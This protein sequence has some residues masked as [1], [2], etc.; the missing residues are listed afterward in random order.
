MWKLSPASDDLL[1]WYIDTMCEGLKNRI[2]NKRDSHGN[3]IINNAI[4][5]I[6]I[7]LNPDGS[8]DETIIKQLLTEKPDTLYALNDNLMK[9]IIKGYNDR[10]FDTYL[11]AKRKTKNR[12]KIESY[13]YKKYNDILKRL[14]EVFDYNGQLASNKEKAYH[15][16]IGQGHNTC[17]YCNR[18]YTITIFESDE[19][20]HT[21]GITRPQLDHWFSKEL[22]P[23]MSLSLYNL[24][25]SCSICNSSVKGTDIYRL[26]THVH[27]YLD[28]TP[29]EPSFRF[30]Y[31]L[32]K[33]KQ[34]EVVIEGLTDTKEK[35]MVKSLKLEEIYKYHG[36]IEVKDI[37]QYNYQY[38]DAYLKTL[39]KGLLKHYKLSKADIYRMLFGTELETSKNLNRP[40]S[41]LKRDILT[42]IGIL[43]DGKF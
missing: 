38:S 5:Q 43:K 31:K 12:T 1:K 29:D 17:T 14:Q 26:N 32:N 23:L 7:P 28:T 42:E 6:L 39:L 27:P 15:L 34:Y 40:L 33:N 37:L 22:Y 9:C 8:D 11:K 16:T 35:N 41:K 20:N 19:N 4:R 10:E 21:L 18:Q 2:K 36:E 24:I 3:L 13:L 30:S 25:P